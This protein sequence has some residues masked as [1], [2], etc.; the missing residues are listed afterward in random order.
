M[1]LPAEAC[2]KRT[3]HVLCVLCASAVSCLSGEFTAETQRTLRL[4]REK[5]ILP[6]GSYERDSECFITS[7]LTRWVCAQT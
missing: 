2:R 5:T 6:T 3:L 4:R 7:P 1:L